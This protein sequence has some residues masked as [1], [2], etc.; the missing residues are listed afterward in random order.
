MSVISYPRM[1]RTRDAGEI[2]EMALRACRIAIDAARNL[3]D[4]IANSSSAAFVEVRQCELELDRIET[5][6]DRDIARAITRVSENTAR[7]LL[8]C[9]KMSTDVERIGDLLWWSAQRIRQDLGTQ[10]LTAQDRRDLRSMSDLLAE[11]L[12]RT[13]ESFESENSDIAE[14]VLRSDAKVDKL[15]HA[16]FDRHLHGRKQAGLT[17]V[18]LI[19]QAL[20]RAGDH[21]KN[22]AE[23]VLHRLEGES[24]LHK[25]S[26]RL[27]SG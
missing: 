23:A 9:L 8:T 6:I 14:K 25:S 18:V 11:M 19:A 20:E 17:Q 21:V 24:M 13:V 4:L 27:L 5:Q 22:V 16:L 3:A 10:G 7:E 12:E 15:R 26:S 2:V 1:K